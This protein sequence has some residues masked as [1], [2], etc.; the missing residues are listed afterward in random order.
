M[1]DPRWALAQRVI[2]SPHLS[3]SPKLVEFFLYVVDCSLREAPEEATEQQIGVHVFHRIPGYNSGDDSIVRSQARLLRLKLAAYF[4]SEGNNE[5]LLVE[6]PKGHYLPVFRPTNHAASAPP[7]HAASLSLEIADPLLETVADP[8]PSS[9]RSHLWKGI[10]GALLCLLIGGLSGLLLER[11][12]SAVPRSDVDTFW[13]PFFVG[14][15]PLIIYSNPLFKG[16]PYTGLKLVPNA[17]MADS[18]EYPGTPDETYTGTGEATAIHELTRVFDTHHADFTLKRS[19]LVTWD[20]AKLRNLVFVGAPS[21][22]GALQ[23]LPTTSDF[24]I[25]LDGND[26]GYILNRHPH[27]GE[28][29]RFVPASPNDEYAVIASIPGIEANRRIAIF[30]G[31]TTNG[32][33]AA[34]EFACTPENVRQITDRVGKTSGVIKPFEAVLHIKLS[35]GVPLQSVL[36]TVHSR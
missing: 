4:S 12:L 27:S 28:P 22:N 23:D 21:Q 1:N 34:V 9:S 16:T 33:Q 3:S 29:K 36:E 18:P 30:T 14:D 17:D 6:I 7:P 19:R 13:K 26:K 20:E 8:P 11:R 31:L 32:T 24:A 15:S 2:A 35:G 10:A 25:E 5:E